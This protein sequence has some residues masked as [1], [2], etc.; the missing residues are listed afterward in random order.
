MI[1]T[2]IDTPDVRVRRVSGAGKHTLSL[3]KHCYVEEGTKADWDALSELHYKGHSLAAGPRFM[4]CVFDDGI[5]RQLVGIIVFSNPMP[6]NKGRNMVFPNMRP[7]TG[8]KDTAIVNKR[9]FVAL[10]RDF[11]WNNR[12]VVDTLFRSAGIAY[13][14]KNLAYRIY[15]TKTSKRF[16]ESN[17]SMGKFN[18]FSIKA[19]MRFTKPTSANAM[20]VGIGFFKHHFKSHPCDVAAL[21]EELR[22][23][24]E[25]DRAYIEGKLREFYYRHSAMEKSGDKRDIGTTR[26]DAKPIEYVLKQTQ[27]IVFGST[28]YWMYQNPDH[29]R[30]NFPTRLPILA[31]DL[32]GPTEK[33]NLA[34]LKRL[35]D[36]L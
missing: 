32:Q 26:V 14:F 36:T 25:G 3:L 29:G 21:M 27:Q 30:E 24:P 18:P 15:C 13:R 19:G 16:V 8:G 10:N 22:A 11:T 6:L 4:R 23:M 31:F 34:A 17:S 28:I 9:R 20:S 1:Q 35:E 2:L 5:E 7:N 33:L 12:T